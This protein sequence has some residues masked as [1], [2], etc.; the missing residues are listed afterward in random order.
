MLQFV[1][2]PENYCCSKEGVECSSY[3]TCNSYRTGTLCGA[4]KQ[5][6]FISYFSNKCIPIS[7]CTTRFLFWVSYIVVSV[8]FTIVLCFVKDIFVLCRKELLFLK[9]KMHRQK[10]EVENSLIKLRHDRCVSEPN[11]KQT[12]TKIPKEISYSA[13]FNVLV[14]FYQLRSLL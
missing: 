2:C 11:S 9:N 10:H 7:T 3:N 6:Y 14:S 12:Q 4:C 8:I 1:P 5:G 13:I